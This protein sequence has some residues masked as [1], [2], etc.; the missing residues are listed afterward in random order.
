MTAD[1]LSTFVEELKR[2]PPEFE[3][4]DPPTQPEHLAGYQRALKVVD[5]PEEAAT[6]Y[7]SVDEARDMIW[8]EM[9]EYAQLVRPQ[10]MLL[11]K[12][13]PGVGKTTAAVRLAE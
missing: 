13:V 8:R 12:A 5:A 1:Y 7:V 6:Q 4:G 2:P 9:M 11:I 10:H 3:R